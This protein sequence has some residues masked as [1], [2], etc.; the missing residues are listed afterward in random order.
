MPQQRLVGL[1]WPG[2]ITL[3]LH[4]RTLLNNIFIFFKYQH[5]HQSQLQKKK[6]LSQGSIRLEW[7]DKRWKGKVCLLSK[8][9]VA[10]ASRQLGWIP[11]AEAMDLSTWQPSTRAPAIVGPSPSAPVHQVGKGSAKMRG[12]GKLKWPKITEPTSAIHR[13]LKA[14]LLINTDGRLIKSESLSL[15]PSHP[16]FFF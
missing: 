2:H 14:K 12:P 3:F 1:I 8:A 6:K 10:R 5:A 4:I 16:F 11:G 15:R 7:M 9:K 13:N